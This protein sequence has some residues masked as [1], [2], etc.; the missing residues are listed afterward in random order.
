MSNLWYKIH[1]G[2][3]PHL[4]LVHGML[5]SANQWLP[6]IEALSKICQPITVELFGHN[7]SPAPTESKLYEPENYVSEFEKIRT[8]LN[9]H[10]WFVCGYSLGAA[11]TIRYALTFPQHL[12]GH[13][14]TNSNSAFATKEMAT[15]WSRQAEQTRDRLIAGGL[16]AIDRIPVHPRH[17]KRL[18]VQLKKQLVEDSRNHNALGIAYTSA[19]T[20]PTSSVRDIFQDNSKPA[21]LVCGRHEKRFQAHCQFARKH[22]PLLQVANVSS[23]HAVNMEADI[24]FNQHVTQFIQSHDA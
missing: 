12:K 24:E 20:T 7:N 19:Y 14:F 2:C 11:L 22:M 3:G 5:S 6:N 18:P 8:S 21:L 15:A 9:I 1:E 13:I 17:A 4:L 10:K 16:D 23:G